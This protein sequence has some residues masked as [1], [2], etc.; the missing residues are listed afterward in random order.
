MDVVDHLKEGLI[1]PDV[2]I[3]VKRLVLR[4][5]LADGGGIVVWGGGEEYDR[6]GT[7]GAGATLASIAK[8]EALWHFAPAVV[9]ACESAATPQVRNVAT[10][11][12]NLLQRPRCW[13]YRNASFEC[14]KKGG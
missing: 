4:S 5:D 14:L 8:S 2:V 9:Q 12:G 13:Y 11:A 3:D 6:T 7:I 10:A 1:E